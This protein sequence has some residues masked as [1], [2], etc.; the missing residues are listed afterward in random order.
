M[1]EDEFDGVNEGGFKVTEGKRGRMGVSTNL[2]TNM[3][4][5]KMTNSMNRNVM[6]DVHAKRGNEG[7]RVSFKIGNAWE[8][9]K[10]V[11]FYVFFLRDP[12]L[13]S[14]V[15]DNGVLVWVMIN[16][17]STGR[18]IEEMGEEVSYRLFA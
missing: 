10:E 14:T 8:K 2:G 4:R 13:L 15:V 6:V 7:N 17:K 18:G 5:R 11:S 9:A 3:N 1:R 12:I 16:S